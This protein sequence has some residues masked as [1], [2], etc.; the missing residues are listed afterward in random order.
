MIL[1]ILICAANLA[2]RDCTEANAR[3]V[4]NVNVDSIGCST[5]ATIAMTTGVNGADDSEYARIKC[6]IG[7]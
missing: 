1:T 5:P 7:R 6:R 2:F 4:V 3:S